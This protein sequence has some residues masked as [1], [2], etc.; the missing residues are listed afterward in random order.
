[1]QLPFVHQVA[2]GLC[3]ELLDALLAPR[4]H[5]FL[6]LAMCGEQYL[7]GRCLEGDAS[8]GADD[9]V[10]EV[11]TAPD[12]EGRSET[13][14]RLADGHRLVPL[15]I[16]RHRAA[17]AESKRV[18]LR[19]AQ[20]GERIARQNPRLIGQAAAGAECLAA[21]DGDAPQAAVDRVARTAWRDGQ[22]ALAQVRE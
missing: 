7:R 2:I 9:G 22:G 16:E 20:A 21:A 13:L 3:H 1:E 14:E 12:A 15:A 6:E 4:E 10:A 8:L 17:R 11:N 5:E 19:G 18:V